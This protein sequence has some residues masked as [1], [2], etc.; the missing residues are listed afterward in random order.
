MLEI[1]AKP[2]PKVPSLCAERDRS[3]PV[4]PQN[5]TRRFALQHFSRLCA[6]AA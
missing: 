3:A 6:L 5:P 1:G 2:G 4:A